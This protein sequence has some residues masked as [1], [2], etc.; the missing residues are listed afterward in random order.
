MLP[1]GVLAIGII[2]SQVGNF[3]AIG[4]RT[5]ADVPS[6]LPHF[7]LPFY[8]ISPV[9]LIN[10]LPA[11]GLMALIAFVSSNSVASSFAR[12][13]HEAYD[14]NLELKGLGVAN[15]AG[16]F[17]QSFTI[18]GGFSRTAV[19][20]DAGA[21]SPLASML[22]VLVMAFVLLFFS[23][24]LEPLPYAILGATIMSV[25]ISMIDV[26][27]LKQALRYD[28]LDALAFGVALTGV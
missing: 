4:I 24:T 11:A 18:V 20:V 23:Q 12:Q 10:L 13:R 8:Q 25:I 1:L 22:S 19:N 7:V 14:A 26:Q 21:Q 17:F 6:G 16:A 15:I 9:E 2:A 5:V 3:A 28:K 27:T